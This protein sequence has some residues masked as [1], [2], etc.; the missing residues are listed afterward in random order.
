MVFD[1]A[2][3]PREAAESCDLAAFGSVASATCERDTKSLAETT[4]AVAYDEALR[5]IARQQAVL[6]GLRSRAATIFSAAALVTAFLGAQ[7]LTR[8]PELDLLAWLAIIAFVAVFVLALA[9]LWPWG[10]QFVLSAEI[11]IEDHLGKQ[12]SDLQ[13]YLAGIWGKNYD[14]NQVRVDQLFWLFRAACAFL[15]IEVVLWLIKLGRG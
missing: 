3:H 7:A 13:K 4:E 15:S 9:I 11:L 12:V 8:E 14:R 10:F 5:A 6:D 2:R 1:K